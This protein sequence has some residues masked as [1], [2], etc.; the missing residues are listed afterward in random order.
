MVKNTTILSKSPYQVG[1]GIQVLH[2]SSTSKQEY[3]TANIAE[4]L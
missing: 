2:I 1:I 4:I 3:E